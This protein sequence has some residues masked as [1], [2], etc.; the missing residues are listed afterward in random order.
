ME[1]KERYEIHRYTLQ[2]N[3]KISFNDYV[4]HICEHYDFDFE[5]IKSFNQRIQDL[6]N[7]QDKRIKKLE[8]KLRVSNSSNASLSLDYIE[9]KKRYDSQ[10]ELLTRK[11]AENSRL[12]L[13]NQQLKQQLSDEENA[14]DLCIDRFNEECEKLR[15]QIKF[16]SEARERFKQSQNQK[17]IECFEKFKEF[18]KKEESPSFSETVAGYWFL[19]ARKVFEYI[20]NQIEE[21]KGEK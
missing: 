3:E 15:K 7:Q 5:K 17:A 18:C 11:L 6:L 16:E 4:E 8:S 1:E 19:S 10:E 13:E 9:L 12:T 14:H 21:L 2:G 20:D